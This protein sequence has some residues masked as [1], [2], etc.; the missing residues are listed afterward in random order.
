MTDEGSYAGRLDRL[1]RL[2]R[3]GREQDPRREAG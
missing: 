2:V 3:L 1:A